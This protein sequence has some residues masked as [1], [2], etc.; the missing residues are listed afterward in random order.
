MASNPGSAIDS[1]ADKDSPKPKKQVSD[2]AKAASKNDVSM[3]VLAGESNC[4]VPIYETC[5]DTRTKINRYMRETTGATNAGFVRM[6][7]TAADAGGSFRPATPRHLTAFLKGKGPTK[8]CENPVFYA[9]YVFFE[10]LRIK[11]GKPKSKKRDEMEG[12]W[13]EAGME[14]IDIS[15]RGVWTENG[16]TPYEDKYVL[17]GGGTV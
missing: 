13:K 9:A 12:V 5:D 6:V 11:E 17:E 1:N 14:L 16:K 3:I 7:N 10:K 15:V 2:K 8:G 4:T